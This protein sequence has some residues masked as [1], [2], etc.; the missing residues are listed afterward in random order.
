[1]QDLVIKKVRFLRRGGELA[2][3]DSRVFSKKGPHHYFEGEVLRL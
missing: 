1:M 3:L 2:D